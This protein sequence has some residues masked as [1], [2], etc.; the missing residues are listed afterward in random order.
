MDLGLTIQT[1]LMETESLVTPSFKSPKTQVKSIAF[2]L[3]LFSCTVAVPVTLFVVF[4]TQINP[5]TPLERA[6]ML[7]QQ[8]PLIDGHNDLPLRLKSLRSKGFIPNL[9]EK[10]S[11]EQRKRY[12]QVGEDLHTD[13]PR[14]KEGMVGAQFWVSYASCD[15]KNPVLTAMEQIDVIKSM[16][17]ENPDVFHWATTAD[18]LLDGFRKG[19]IASLI[20][21]EGGHMINSS[22][23]ILRRHYEAGV[24]YMTLTHNC[25][26]PWATSCC[27]QERDWGLNEQGIQIIQEMNKLGMMIDLSH[28]SPQTMRDAI[29]A[30]KAPVIFSH[31]NAK[32][33]C[34]HPRNV[35]DDVLDMVKENGGIVMVRFCGIR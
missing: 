29:K 30:S 7:A 25:N 12:Q 5:Q 23:Q 6:Q 4:I 32:S 20:G 33:L 1:R 9:R 11:A 21:V 34:G 14:L 19:K 16:I 31:S 15:D 27:D 8:V 13:I 22:L 26:T 35:P 3:L 2:L 10:M 24:R 28:T 17:L 18:Q